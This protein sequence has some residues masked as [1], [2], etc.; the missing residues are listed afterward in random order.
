MLIME[1]TDVQPAG[2]LWGAT[3]LELLRGL[4]NV[5][6][7]ARAIACAWAGA[8]SDIADQRVSR[9][10]YGPGDPAVAQDLASREA[11]A[12]DNARRYERTREK[13]R[14]RGEFLR[15]GRP[16][17]D[18]AAGIHQRYVPAWNATR[19]GP[20]SRA[21]DERPG[22]H[23]RGRR[24]RWASTSTNC[25]IYSVRNKQP[26]TP[27][28]DPTQVSFGPASGKNSCMLLLFAIRGSDPKAK[29]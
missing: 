24:P 13:H 28:L 10:R 20:G 16:R 2:C 12:I 17:P 19:T 4:A 14:E 9:Q 29:D 22:H 8:W 7:C 26:S 6:A 15:G 18:D 1:I 25:S 3:Q 11:L 23:R 27:S 21:L 5:L